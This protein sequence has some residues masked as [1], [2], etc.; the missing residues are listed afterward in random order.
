MDHPFRSCSFFPE[1]DVWTWLVWWRGPFPWW[2]EGLP[3]K[4]ITKLNFEWLPSK[5]HPVR[6][7]CIP[8]VND[9]TMRAR[10]WPNGVDYKLVNPLHCSRFAVRMG[11][12]TMW[13]TESM[14]PEK[15]HTQSSF[16][17]KVDVPDHAHYIVALFIFV[18]GTLG[19]AGNA[20]VMFA[21]YR[22]VCMSVFSPPRF[23]LWVIVC[24]SIPLLHQT[25][26][27]IFI[28]DASFNQS[29]KEML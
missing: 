26:F 10:H 3:L 7:P 11:C 16:F 14:E 29:P 12:W 6:L 27:S 23:L 2:E 1:V 20:L 28:M 13:S 4:T 15:A 22:W 21:F 19:I 17:S 24:V 5:E 18:I 9:T 25:L 8:S